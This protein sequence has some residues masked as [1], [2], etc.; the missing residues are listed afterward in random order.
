MTTL[1][2]R[3]HVYRDDLADV[4]LQGR[5]EAKRFV[6]GVKQRIAVPVTAIHRSPAANAMQISQA[7]FGEDVDVFERAGGW[8][9]IKT[10]TDGY[11]GYV[12]ENALTGD[13]PAITHHV[14]AH[15]TLLYPKPDL[16]T[17]PAIVLPLNAGLSVVDQEGDYLKLAAGGY[18][19]AAHA[20]P[21]TSHAA[22]FVSV[23]ERFLHTPYFWGGKTAAGLDCS[24]LV[25]VSLTA[26]GVACPRDTDMQEAE[27][28]TALQVNNL[29]GLKRGD[30]VFWKGHVGIM[31]DATNLLH[32][33]GHHMMTVIEPL[34][35][36]VERSAAKG[37][38][39]SSIRR[40]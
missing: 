34:R 4:A 29:D 2:K 20:T 11:V 10:R 35:D 26:T 14:S 9:W 1:D 21:I 38:P 8:T 25:Q 19:F 3:R 37:T 24:G 36:A 13:M 28:G 7:L 31:H 22:D 15:A 5:I 27:L 30:L 39:V 16:K 32:A 18:V 40:L 6:A 17:V 12:A 33:N 23:A